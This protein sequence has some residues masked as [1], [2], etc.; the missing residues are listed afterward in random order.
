MI[1]LEKGKNSHPSEEKER[2]ETDS[3]THAAYQ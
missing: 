3:G 1:L 2:A